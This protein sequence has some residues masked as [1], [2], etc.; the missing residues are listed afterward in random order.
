M[1]LRHALLGFLSTE[2]ATG[3]DIA[4]EFDGSLGW[5]WH[6]SHSQIYP[7]LQR[8]EAD[9][10]ISGEEIAGG[11]GKPRRVYRLT[12]AGAAE[13]RG[14]LRSPTA[15]AAVRDV[16]RVKLMFLDDLPVEAVREHLDDHVRH[17]EGLLAQYVE[18][19]RQLYAGTFPRLVKRVASRPESASGWIRELKVMAVEGNIARART[20]ISWAQDALTRLVEWEAGS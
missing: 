5:F 9:G 1:S 11:P 13:L 17:F 10:L 4:R 6:A 19:A 20:E 7:E 15:Y 3:F 18:Q 14:W 16:E 12:L 8:L 2:P